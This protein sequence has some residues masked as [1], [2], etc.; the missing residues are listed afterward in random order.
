MNY[1]SHEEFQE[2]L[3]EIN[4]SHAKRLKQK[5][6]EIAK[7]QEVN[8]K[9]Y[10]ELHKRYTKGLNHNKV[11]VLRVIEELQAKFLTK[12]L[13]YR[14]EI[15]DLR[16]ELNIVSNLDINSFLKKRGHLFTS[17]EIDKLLTKILRPKSK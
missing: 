8:G 4:K 16:N 6:I 12:E 14:K 1:I 3:C 9:A 7:I 15:E 11:E 17:D 2:I 5:E 13:D 10:T